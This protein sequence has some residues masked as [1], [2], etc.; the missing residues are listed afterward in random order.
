MVLKTRFTVYN[1]FGTFIGIYMCNLSHIIYFIDR[2]RCI[3]SLAFKINLSQHCHG[4]PGNSHAPFP[5]VA[6][7]SSYLNF[8]CPYVQCPKYIKNILASIFQFLFLRQYLTISC[9][10]RREKNLKIKLTFSIFFY[11]F[12][13]KILS[14]RT[15]WKKNIPIG[16][17]KIT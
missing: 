2:C 6:V 9:C 7:Q 12:Y 10:R 4:V 17:K 3:S 11:M 5:L 16:N 8:V 1:C 14:S 13:R 15:F